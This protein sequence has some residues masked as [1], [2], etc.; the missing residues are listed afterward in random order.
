MTCCS[1]SCAQPT[2]HDVH[3]TPQFDRLY[4]IFIVWLLLLLFLLVFAIA[5]EI[6]ARTLTHT[7]RRHVWHIVLHLRC[8]RI[9]GV[10]HEIMWECV[11]H[12]FIIIIMCVCA[13]HY[14]FIHSNGSITA[15]IRIYT[16]YQVVLCCVVPLQSINVHRSMFHH[17]HNHHRVHTPLTCLKLKIEKRVGVCPV[18]A[19]ITNARLS[20]HTQTIFNSCHCCVAT[21]ERRTN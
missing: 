20:C 6:F 15:S 1:C 16:K 3:L 4:V 12:I 9:D 8:C 10:W 7:H 18:P 17:H 2:M 21:W 19:Q 11:E 5:L 13:S 14:P